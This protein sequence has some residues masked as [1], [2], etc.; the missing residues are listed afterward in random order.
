MK[1]KC[2]LKARTCV[3]AISL[4]SLLLLLNDCVAIRGKVTFGTALS[5]DN[6]NRIKPG[7]TSF[8]ELLGWFGP[9]GYIVDGTQTLLDLSAMAA[10]SPGDPEVERT[11]SSPEGQVIL[12]YQYVAQTVTYVGSKQSPAELSSQEMLI[13]L[14]KSSHLVVSVIKGEGG[15][16]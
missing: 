11:L 8:S 7:V 5:E 3:S 15:G 16:R 2:D 10:Y 12:I 4:L 13:Y 1:T 9:P 6:I 14:D